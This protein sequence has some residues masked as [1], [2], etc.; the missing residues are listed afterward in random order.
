MEKEEKERKRSAVPCS[1]GGIDGTHRF[2]GYVIAFLSSGLLEMLMAIE[3]VSL[4]LVWRTLET[5]FSA[6][7]WAQ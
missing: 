6:C 3:K 5:V 2:E 7:L 4:Q 1:L